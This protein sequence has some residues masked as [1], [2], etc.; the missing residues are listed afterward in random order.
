MYGRAILARLG[1]AVP[2]ATRLNAKTEAVLREHLD[3]VDLAR[4]QESA[5]D[6]T[7]E[8]AVAWSLHALA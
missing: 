7:V 2:W 1:A 6:V 8:G 4:L 5:S 3:D